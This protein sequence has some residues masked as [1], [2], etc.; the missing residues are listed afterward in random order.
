MD[1]LNSPAFKKFW[2]V[3]VNNWI[4]GASYNGKELKAAKLFP[5]FRKFY[6]IKTAGDLRYFTP[7]KHISN[8]ELCKT[9]LSSDK[10]VIEEANK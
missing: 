4:T 6:F 8:E 5:T 10:S 2:V 7:H 1:N 9:L 3:T